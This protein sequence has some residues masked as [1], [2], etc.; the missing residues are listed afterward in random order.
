MVASAIIGAIALAGLATSAYSTVQQQKS[1]KKAASAQRQAQN[2]QTR[3]SRRQAIRSAQIQRAQAISAGGAFGINASSPGSSGGGITG[4]I[5]SP[6][7]SSLGTSTQLSGISRNIEGYLADANKF[8][9]IGTLG[10]LATG[11]A[12]SF[13]NPAP[14]KPPTRAT[15]GSSFGTYANNQPGYEF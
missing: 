15:S 7:G 4:G 10:G 14:N 9:T 8:A 3:Q 12:L 1:Q 13:Y 2:V 11:A 5:T 6:L